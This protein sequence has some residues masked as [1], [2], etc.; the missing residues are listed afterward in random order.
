MNTYVKLNGLLYGTSRVVFLKLELFS[1][2]YLILDTHTLSPKM[3]Y[4]TLALSWRILALC[5]GLVLFLLV[6]DLL[7][8]AHTTALHC[9]SSLFMKFAF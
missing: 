3:L 8:L 7:K 1:F 2:L 6:E 5:G 4:K 9:S